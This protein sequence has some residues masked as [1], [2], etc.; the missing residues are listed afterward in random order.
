MLPPLDIRW[1]GQ[2]Y[3]L[4]PY[5]TRETPPRCGCLV[6]RTERA[7]GDG[8]IYNRI[9]DDTAANTPEAALLDGFRRMIEAQRTAP[10]P[11]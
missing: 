7:Y 10:P 11:I 5:T 8:Y 6:L 4:H 9:L 2:T 3:Y 1:A